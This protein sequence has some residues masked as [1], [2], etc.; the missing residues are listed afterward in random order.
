M[1]HNLEREE[2][3]RIKEASEE[4][5]KPFIKVVTV[6]M[7]R[8]REGPVD[9]FNRQRIDLFDENNSRGYVITDVLID[10][11]TGVVESKGDLSLG[12]LIGAFQL[13]GE[14]LFTRLFSIQLPRDPGEVNKKNLYWQRG[15]IPKSVEMLADSLS[16]ARKI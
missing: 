5:V 4:L 3:A 10:E 8:V 9:S 6:A 2:R 14:N 15:S 1:L 12:L 13:K 7:Q 11:S 16:S